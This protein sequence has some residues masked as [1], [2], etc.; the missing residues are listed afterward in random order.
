MYAVRMRS[1]R[2]LGTISPNAR[3]VWWKKRMLPHV[4]SYASIDG[5][6]AVFIT[7]SAGLFFF[8]SHKPFIWCKFGNNFKPQ[9]YVGGF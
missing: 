7:R 3:P 4:R 9:K 5:A 8:S 1:G 6:S 2:L